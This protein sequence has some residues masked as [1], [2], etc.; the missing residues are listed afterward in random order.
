M[1]GHVAEVSLFCDLFFRFF[2]WLIF[3]S[4]PILVNLFFVSI[5]LEFKYV[6]T[7]S[8]VFSVFFRASLL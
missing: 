7:V 5:F 1:S 6:L 2:A 8:Y 3:G 4:L